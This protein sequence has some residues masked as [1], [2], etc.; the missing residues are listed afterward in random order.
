MRKKLN[1]LIV[2]FLALCAVLTLS[3]CDSEVPTDSARVQATDDPNAPAYTVTLDPTGGTWSDGSSGAV[4]VSVKRGKL[5]ISRPI[6]RN[7]RATRSMAGIRLTA[8]PGP[9]LER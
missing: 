2:A 7:M 6:C 9:G 3:A 5:S 4:T 1:A 8:R